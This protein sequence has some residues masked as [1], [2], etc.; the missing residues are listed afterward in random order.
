MVQYEDV[1]MKEILKEMRG[2]DEESQS[3]SRL[4]SR[5]KAKSQEETKEIQLASFHPAFQWA[6]T[7]FDAPLNFE[8]RAPFP[9]I[10]LLRAARV[11]EYASE[12]WTNVVVVLLRVTNML[13]VGEHKADC[14]L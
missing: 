4:L 9:V 8:K 7:D 3:K 12:V 6:D 10:N 2:P 11:R 1:E 14:R 5:A 13:H